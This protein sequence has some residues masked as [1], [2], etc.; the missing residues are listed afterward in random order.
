[1]KIILRYH[2]LLIHDIKGITKIHGMDSFKIDFYAYVGQM[3]SYRHA[4][5]DLLNLK[6]MGFKL[7][8]LFLCIAICIRQSTP[9]VSLNFNLVTDMESS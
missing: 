9:Y 2:R 1:M 8:P 5:A 7:F 3:V 4:Q 6:T